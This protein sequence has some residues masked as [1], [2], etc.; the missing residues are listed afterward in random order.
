MRFLV[1]HIHFLTAQTAYLVLIFLQFLVR[2]LSFELRFVSEDQQPLRKI[3]T[4]RMI[5]PAVAYL[6]PIEAF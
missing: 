5:Q 1:L 3:L 2:L 4:A 6:I